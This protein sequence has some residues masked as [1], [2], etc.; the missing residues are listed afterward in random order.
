MDRLKERLHSG[1]YSCVIS[2]ADGTVR[3]FN[4][5]GITDLFIILKNEPEMLREASVAD[6]VVGKAA[7]ALLISGGVSRVYADIISSPALDLL[8]EHGIEV[9]YAIGTDHIDNRDG[10]G[11]C[12]MELLSRDENNPETIKDKVEQFLRG[13]AAC[14]MNV[15][16][17]VNQQN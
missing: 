3:T 14:S 13:K 15:K 4:R 7:A 6:K 8:Q 2:A 17:Q 16:E 11:W 12:P 1:H 9:T 10:T 5:R